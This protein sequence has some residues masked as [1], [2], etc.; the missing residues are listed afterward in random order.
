MNCG[1]KRYESRAKF[2]PKR[3]QSYDKI[4]KSCNNSFRKEVV[5][6]PAIVIKYKGL[7]IEI[8]AV[9]LVLLLL[10]TVFD[11]FLK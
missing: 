5:N 9:T 3:V 11:G 1:L 2:E 8:Y 10:G 7:T 6:M 4:G